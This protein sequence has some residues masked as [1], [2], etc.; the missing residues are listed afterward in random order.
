MN[1]GRMDRRIRFEEAVGVRDPDT[2]ESI[3][4]WL[5][6]ATVWAERRPLRGSELY[7]ARQVIANVE[8]KWRIRWPQGFTVTPDSTMRIR[9]IFDGEREHDILSVIE[10]GRR[11]GL[12]MLTKARAE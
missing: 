1:A 3:P 10:V 11:E 12:E 2:N 6:R 7:A 9:D 4:T 5:P 8:I